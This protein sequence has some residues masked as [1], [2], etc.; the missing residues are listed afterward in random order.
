MDQALYISRSHFHI[1]VAGLKFWKVVFSRGGE[2]ECF[3]FKKSRVEERDND[4]TTG[5]HDWSQFK[6][7]QFLFFLVQNC[8]V[9]V[10]TFS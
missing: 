3:V 10:S 5:Y 1:L 7:I 4:V 2:V 6:H 8:L 9:K